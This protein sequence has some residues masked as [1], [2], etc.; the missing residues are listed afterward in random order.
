M[1]NENQNTY[2]QFGQNVEEQNNQREQQNSY[3]QDNSMKNNYQN[4]SNQSGNNGYGSYNTNTYKG[5]EPISVLEWVGTILLAAIP[6]VGLI[7]YIIW[8]F[9]GDVKKSKSNYC[10]AILAIQ[11]GAIVLSIVLTVVFFAI[12]LTMASMY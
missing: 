4:N 11:L 7:L 6:C 8:A 2:N 12:G 9:S 10:K 1:E 5:E 3:Y